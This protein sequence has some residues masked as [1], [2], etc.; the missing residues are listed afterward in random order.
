VAEA[1][2]P[3]YCGQCG[4][5]IQE[6]DKFCGAC[7]AR[8]P[9]AAPNAAN[10]EEIPQQVYAPP[11]VLSRSRSRTLILVIAV[12]ALL[13]LLLAGA[14][15]GA[16]GALGFLGI[17]RV[18]HPAGRS[19]DPAFDPLLP[20]LQERTTAPIMLPA[21]LPEELKNVALDADLSGDSYGIL[22]LHRP[23]GNKVESYVHANDAGTLTASPEPQE[24]SEYFEAT[25]EETVELPDGT[26][27]TL[28]YMKPAIEGGNYGPFWEGTF[29]KQGYTYTL[30]V[31]LADSSGD[32]ARRALSTMIEVPDEG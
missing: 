25:R 2:R 21:E 29:E 32:V 4:N 19:P 8:I 9:P 6:G 14:G 16:L 23:T 24:T 12:R 17:D 22:F 11:V 7:G 15:V 13:V 28:R 1:D 5:P 30:S 10:P 31:P 3:V 27:A 18:L 26:E 20:T